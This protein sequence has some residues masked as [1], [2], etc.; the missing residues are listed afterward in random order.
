LLTY[1]LQKSGFSLY[2]NVI[3]N[4]LYAGE[5]AHTEVLYNV[6][7]LDLA[8]TTACTRHSDS[9]GSGTPEN[10]MIQK[11]REHMADT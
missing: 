2:S 6:F 10:A 11:N 9:T 8:R 7:A 4:L 1:L 5:Q 3:A